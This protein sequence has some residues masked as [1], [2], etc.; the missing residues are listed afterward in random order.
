M[1]FFVDQV[2]F[3]WNNQI[4]NTNGYA[5]TRRVFEAPGTKRIC[6]KNGLLASTFSEGRVD[7]PIQGLFIENFVVIAEGDLFRDNLT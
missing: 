2:F 7:K 3:L 1:A 6:Q 5:G 4:L